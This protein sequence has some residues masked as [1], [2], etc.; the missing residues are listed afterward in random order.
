MT[1]MPRPNRRI[2][3]PEILKGLTHP[4]R[5][6]V[7]R[8]LA[9]FGPATVTTLARQTGSDPGQLSYHVRELAKRGFIEPAPEFARDRR[10]S[11]WRL[12]PGSVSWSA[13]EIEAPD[14]RAVADA[15]HNMT[16]ADE[17]ERLR[18]FESSRDS[19]PP[20]WVQA[21]E[22]SNSYLRL[23]PQELRELTGQ[24][25]ELIGAYGDHEGRSASRTPQPDQADDADGRQSVFIFL[26]AFPEKP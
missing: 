17:F 1:S 4:L 14:G 20:E 5:R 21:A 10:E 18:A 24:I 15:L 23:T 13:S 6:Q 19:W 3:D 7:F 25:N 8:L 16:V 11:W 9:Q 2:T 22:T 12:A 26:H